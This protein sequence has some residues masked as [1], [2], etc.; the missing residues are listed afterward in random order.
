MRDE[1]VNYTVDIRVTSKFT[2]TSYHYVFY[3]R[4][5]W[6][7]VMGYVLSRDSRRVQILNQSVV[8]GASQ[9]LFTNM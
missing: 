4:L 9:C 6:I 3:I 5:A 2:I 7:R 1:R 8:R